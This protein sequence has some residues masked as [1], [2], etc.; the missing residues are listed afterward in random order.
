M[1]PAG[2][3][4]SV[5]IG[6][7]TG[8]TQS[9]DDIV[10]AASGLLG[11]SGLNVLTYSIQKSSILD[12]MM[13]V[14]HIPFTAQLRIQTT[15]DYDSADDILSIVKGQF[16]AA[17]GSSDYPTSGSVVSVTTPDG[18]SQDTG[19]GIQG[20]PNPGGAS[21]GIGDL[22]SNFFS[23]LQSTTTTLLIAV[24]GI[25]VLILILAAYGPNTGAIA[26]AVT[27]A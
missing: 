7:R 2:S 5:S 16:Y 19:E 8:I 14:Y 15:G 25:L 12:Q 3:I 10:N 18:S 26:R 23:G 11:G 20:N 27:L 21:T 22:V 6:G 24:A 4:L 13:T 17:T 1:I 9:S